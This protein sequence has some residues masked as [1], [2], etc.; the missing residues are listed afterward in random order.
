MKGL[1]LISLSVFCLHGL[2][3][4]AD[5]GLDPHEQ[6]LLALHLGIGHPLSG[7]LLSRLPPCPSATQ[8]V[9]Q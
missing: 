7:A 3:A 5:R 8:E 6:V 2:C 9:L 1:A 4:Q